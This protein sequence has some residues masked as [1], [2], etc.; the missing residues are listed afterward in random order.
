MALN[1]PEEARRIFYRGQTLAKQFSENSTSAAD[2]RLE[3]FRTLCIHYGVEV[4]GALLGEIREPEHFDVLFSSAMLAFGIERRI[5]EAKPFIARFRV[6]PA[7]RVIAYSQLAIR[8][9]PEDKAEVLAEMRRLVERMT[10]RNQ[11][12]DA[13]FR[14]LLVSPNPEDLVYLNAHMTQRF[15]LT[16][17]QM[18]SGDIVTLIGVCAIDD[19]VWN[20]QKAIQGLALIQT[21]RIRQIGERQ[22]WITLII[23]P[24]AR[25]FELARG[26]DGSPYQA[27]IRRMAQDA[28]DPSDPSLGEAEG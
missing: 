4:C 11:Y 26:L 9:C 23:W 3:M 15:N 25:L 5:K 17:N 6:S 21:P 22:L 16:P 28:R 12:F 2:T 8:A 20:M 10:D 18:T 27:R 7:H 19:G 14:I 24:R 1:V 13:R